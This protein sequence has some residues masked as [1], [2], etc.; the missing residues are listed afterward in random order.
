M[1][2]KL[3]SLNLQR[4]LISGDRLHSKSSLL[5]KQNFIIQS[6]LAYQPIYSFSQ[7]GKNDQN[8]AKK[9]QDQKVQKQENK[10]DKKV[11]N[12]DNQN[13]KENKAEQDKNEEKQGAQKIY[14]KINNFNIFQ[15]LDEARDW[16]ERY[17]IKRL[18]NL[19]EKK[20][21][22][23]KKEREKYDK[24]TDEERIEM[25]IAIVNQFSSE[26]EEVDEVDILYF[27][28]FNQNSMIERFAAKLQMI[29][30]IIF[31]RKLLEQKMEYY[32]TLMVNLGY[33]RRLLN[34]SLPILHNE[35]QKMFHQRLPDYYTMTRWELYKQMKH[36]L[37]KQFGTLQVDFEYDGYG[38][39]VYKETEE[40]KKEEERQKEQTKQDPEEA[41]QE[42]SNDQIQEKLRQLNQFNT[43]LALLEDLPVDNMPAKKNTQINNETEA[44]ERIKLLNH[45]GWTRTETIKNF[46]GY[47]EAYRRKAFR[48]HIFCLKEEFNQFMKNKDQLDLSKL[49]EKERLTIFTVSKFDPKEQIRRKIRLWWLNN[50][51]IFGFGLAPGEDRSRVIIDLSI[52]EEMKKSKEEIQESTS[53]IKESY[54]DQMATHATSLYGGAAFLLD[55]TQK[56][57]KMEQCLEFVRK[58]DKEF[59]V[60]DLE[61]HVKTTFETVYTAHLKGMLYEVDNIVQDQALGYFRSVWNIWTLQKMKP[62]FSRIWGIEKPVCS[63][64]EINSSNQPEFNFQVY[65]QTNHCFVDIKDEKT[66]KDGSLER[67][68]RNGYQIVC[69]FD[70]TEENADYQWKITSVQP[71][72]KTLL[73]A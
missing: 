72:E 61:Q 52:L 10:N 25:D 51:Q 53:G 48:H 73:L 44:L 7:T 30:C 31:H 18:K 54:N 69:I 39:I 38:N 13:D 9:D 8:G 14:E 6:K 43:G 66:V 60:E 49:T 57:T 11:E 16:A 70:E 62:K 15:S 21:S 59:S 22:Q 45:V 32:E 71:I 28:Y 55:N 5:K 40:S 35:L 67:V 68:M 29:K 19:T 63:S 46:L 20:M 4:V 37:D 58:Y 27:M 2:R 42:L 50:Q 65:C 33:N 26:Q 23:E 17:R 64:S 47:S 41:K 34:Q 36:R 24:L 12:K 3:F 1:L 56:N